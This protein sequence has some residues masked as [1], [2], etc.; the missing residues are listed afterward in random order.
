MTAIDFYG[1]CEALGIDP[2]SYLSA[3]KKKMTT[4][5]HSCPILMRSITLN[6]RTS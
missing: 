6:T 4:L 3:V 5:I 2:E 1:K